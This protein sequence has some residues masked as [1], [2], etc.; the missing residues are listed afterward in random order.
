[1]IVSHSV[2]FYVDDVAASVQFYGSLLGREPMQ[3]SDGFAIFMLDGGL[4]LGLW[5]NAEI[6]PPSTAKPA[7]MELNCVVDAAATVDAWYADWQAKGVAMALPPTDLPFGR[8]FVAVD[9]DGHRLRVCAM[10]G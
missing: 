8:S 7:S 9:P 1:M 10:A 3:Q 2:I 6:V 4:G 5:K